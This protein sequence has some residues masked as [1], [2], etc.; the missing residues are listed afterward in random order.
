MEWED[1]D[2]SELFETIREQ[3][4]PADAEQMLWALEHVIAAG[5]L[6][7]ALHDH[8]AAA[9]ICALAYRDAETPKNSPGKP[10]PPI[11]RRRP[12]ERRLRR[13]PTRPFLTVV[14]AR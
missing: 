11:C 5:K 12:L 6:D 14:P 9:A 13:P 1:L 4:A 2:P 10:V 7:P 8:F 3:A